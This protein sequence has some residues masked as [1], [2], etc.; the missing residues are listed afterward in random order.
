MGSSLDS[1][2]KKGPKEARARWALSG[3][4]KVE[5][6]I[7]VE[8]KNGGWWRELGELG[9]F[10]IIESCLNHAGLFGERGWRSH[11]EGGWRP[12]GDVAGTEVQEIHVGQLSGNIVLVFSGVTFGCDNLFQHLLCTVYELFCGD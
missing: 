1:I 7:E 11:S 10:E 3:E 12:G 8:R 5:E 9:G 6:L 4:S 2:Q